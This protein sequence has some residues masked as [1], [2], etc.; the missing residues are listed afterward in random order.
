MDFWKRQVFVLS[1]NQHLAAEI[2]KYQ[3]ADKPWTEFYRSCLKLDFKNLKKNTS[4]RDNFSLITRLS[5]IFSR[6]QWLRT[7][8]CK[9]MMTKAFTLYWNHFGN[10][11]LWW[12]VLITKKYSMTHDFAK[13]N[14]SWLASFVNANLNE[15]RVKSLSFLQNIFSPND[16]W[17]KNWSVN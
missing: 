5:R 8:H 17:I 1:M 3:I 12:M 2:S 7:N 16:F 6:L 13:I 11:K 4:A 9:Q 14:C 10:N 15:F